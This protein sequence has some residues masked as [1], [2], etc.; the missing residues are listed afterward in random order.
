MVTYRD[1]SAS[2]HP[3]WS[4][5]GSPQTQKLCPVLSRLPLGWCFLEQPLPSLGMSPMPLHSGWWRPCVSAESLR[6]RAEPGFVVSL[7]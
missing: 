3:L 1:D 4:T 2:S 7:R 6:A 5:A